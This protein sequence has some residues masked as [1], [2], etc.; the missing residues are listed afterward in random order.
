M[1]VLKRVD[2]RSGIHVVV[3]ARMQQSAVTVAAAGGS[4]GVW[5][6]GDV[7]LLRPLYGADLTHDSLL[8]N[9]TWI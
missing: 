4:R 1:Y 8:T 3:V 7:G 6:R 2:S 5:E 9:A